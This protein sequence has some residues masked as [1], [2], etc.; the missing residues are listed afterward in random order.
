[1]GRIRVL[2]AQALHRAWCRVW[3]PLVFNGHMWPGA[4][5]LMVLVQMAS[6]ST[7]YLSGALPSGLCGPWLT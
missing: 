6:V 7:P 2:G 4:A 5:T 3:A 1:M